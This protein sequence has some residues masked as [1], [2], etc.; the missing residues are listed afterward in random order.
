MTTPVLHIQLPHG[1]EGS[2]TQAEDSEVQTESEDE[3]QMRKRARRDNSYNACQL[4]SGD[5]YTAEGITS[6]RPQV[7]PHRAGWPAAAA[8]HAWLG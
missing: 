3:E 4:S 1:Q 8:G 5:V 7:L 6:E 2:D